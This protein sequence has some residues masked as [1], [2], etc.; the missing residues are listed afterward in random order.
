[1]SRTDAVQFLLVKNL[2]YSNATFSL[3]CKSKRE[4]PINQHRGELNEIAYLYFAWKII[5]ISEI[6]HEGGY[7]LIDD[8]CYETVT[9]LDD[10][11]EH[12]SSNGMYFIDRSQPNS[13]A[14]NS[15]PVITSH[16]EMSPAEMSNTVSTTLTCTPNYENIPKD[17]PTDNI[18][19]GIYVINP[20]TA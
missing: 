2:R 9:N 11:A 19:C 7:N 14:V 18:E 16:P 17:S 4:I 10:D 12:I 3:I 13:A 6:Q 5:P 20:E 15:Q 8:E 1:M